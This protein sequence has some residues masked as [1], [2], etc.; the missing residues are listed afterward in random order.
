MK[1]DQSAV[2][3]DE[4]PPHVALRV[5]IAAA[6]LRQYDVAQKAGLTETALS[7]ILSGRKVVDGETFGRIGAAIDELAAA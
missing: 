4:L 2:R 6:D 3:L 5:R 7:K 1:T